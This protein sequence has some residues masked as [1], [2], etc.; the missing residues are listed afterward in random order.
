[1]CMFICHFLVWLHATLSPAKTSQYSFCW[2]TRR[3]NRS[4]CVTGYLLYTHT[5]VHII[6]NPLLINTLVIIAGL[7]K[8]MHLLITDNC[9]VG[10]RVTRNYC[11][12]IQDWVMKSKFLTSVA[13]SLCFVFHYHHVCAVF[14]LKTYYAK[15]LYFHRYYLW[16]FW[17]CVTHA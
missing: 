8:R 5:Y 17:L 15:K 11:I 1:M 12:I 7:A 4:W 3:W 10:Q 9:N 6:A 2:V 14:C 13:L 16:Y